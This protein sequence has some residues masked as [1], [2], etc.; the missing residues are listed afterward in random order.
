MKKLFTLFVSCLLF[1]GTAGYSPV[2]AADFRSGETVIASGDNLKDLYLFGGS[3]RVESPVNNDVVAA[4][5]D[6][7]INRDV[8]GSLI[9]AGGNI[10]SLGKV[11]NTVRAAGGNITID[12]AIT[13]DLVVSGGSVVVNKNAQIGG[14]VA[15]SGGTLVLDGP[16]K[17]NVLI[18]G[19]QVTLNGPI[20]G[21]VQGE[22]GSLTLGPNARINGNLTY[23]SE[24]KASV[25]NGAVVSGKT[26]YT[27]V[28]EDTKEDA[29][30]FITAGSIYKLVT[31]I[32]ISILFIFFFT[33]ALTAIVSRMAASTVQSGAIGFTFIILFPVLAAIALI[34]I[35]LGIGAFITYA[36]IFLLSIFLVK[37]FL[38]WWVMRWWENR[39]KRQYVLD[40]K[41]GIIGPILLFILTLIPI[42]G[43]LI[44]AILFFIAVG[45]LLQE[46]YYLMSGQRIT[47]HN[48]K[49][50]KAVAKPKVSAPRRKR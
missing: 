45:A 14:D 23:S 28:K 11:G 15:F 2:S 20:D 6:I 32:I 44:A 17:G 43:W 40:W 13:R 35:W 26:T 49:P 3:I 39:N 12:N 21:N 37:I 25:S 16:V 30:A 47:R 8:T 33:R 50:V 7:S 36:L 10:R 46:L 1:L 5:G 42:L 48:T 18:S 38:G 34:L 31:D 41:A 24:R 22:I 29:Q 27:P 9:V 4:G 19:G